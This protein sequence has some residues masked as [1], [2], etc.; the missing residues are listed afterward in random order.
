MDGNRESKQRHADGA[1]RDEAILDLARGEKSCGV[2]A[3]TD[4][5]GQCCLQVPAMRFVDVQDFTAVKDNHELEQRAE[6]PEVGIAD[7]CKVQ[8]A[9]WPDNLN[10][11]DQIAEDVEP[12]FP[13]RVGGRNAGNGET[14]CQTDQR[15]ST[16]DQACIQLPS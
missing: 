12:E 5:Y 4:A 10:L 9:I 2:A 16:K 15:A 13:G 6:K 11:L 1:Q 14:R 8:C 3:K 7:D